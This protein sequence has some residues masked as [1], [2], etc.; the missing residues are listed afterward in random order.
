MF[1]ICV[2][3]ALVLLNQVRQKVSRTSQA[4]YLDG[5]ITGSTHEVRCECNGETDILKADLS[6]SDKIDS[7]PNSVYENVTLETMIL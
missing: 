4:R 7:T 1:V 3:L 5:E 2:I 6:F